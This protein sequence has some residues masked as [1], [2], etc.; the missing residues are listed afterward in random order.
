MGKLPG[1]RFWLPMHPV[2]AQHKSLISNTDMD[3][4]DVYE[5]TTKQQLN[6]HVKTVQPCDTHFTFF[7]LGGENMSK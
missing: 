5:T 4:F 2:C 7:S 1:A 3:K 6:L